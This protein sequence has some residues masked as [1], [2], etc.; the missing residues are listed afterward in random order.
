MV[1]T[2]RIKNFDVGR[3]LIDQGSSADIIYGEAFEKL[4]FKTEDLK[5]YNG[6]LVGFTNEAVEVR[7]YV[8]VET[9]FGRNKI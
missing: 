2:L 7:G 5:P 3:V 9:I 4:W 6:T 1:V 8:E